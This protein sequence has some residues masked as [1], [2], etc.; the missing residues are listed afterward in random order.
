MRLSNALP[1]PLPLPGLVPVYIEHTLGYVIFMYGDDYLFMFMCL[2][3][4][5]HQPGACPLT[6]IQLCL[7]L[8][9]S[10]SLSISHSLGDN[11]LTFPYQSIFMSW[12]QNNS[13][14]LR[15]YVMCMWVPCLGVCALWNL[16]RSRMSCSHGT[17]SSPPPPLLLP[18]L[19]CWFFDWKDYFF[20]WN[21]LIMFAVMLRQIRRQHTAAAY[22]I[23]N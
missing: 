3:W 12:R 9:F 15:N 8:S 2:P 22:S 6:Y 4:S 20:G 7:S 11:S 23:N 5:D 16:D 13:E 19:A 17:M 14:S 21:S 10:L 1:V 18:H